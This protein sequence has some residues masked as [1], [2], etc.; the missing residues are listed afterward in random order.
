M[1]IWLRKFT[2]SKLREYYEKQNQQ[3]NE[4]LGSQTSK[5]KEGKIELPGHFKGQSGKRSPKY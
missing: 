1:P 4:D 2:F 5:I 3:N